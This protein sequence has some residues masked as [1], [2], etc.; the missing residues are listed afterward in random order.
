M[1]PRLELVIWAKKDTSE[2]VMLPMMNN[3]G[4]DVQLA[5]NKQ[6]GGSWLRVDRV[7]GNGEMIK[8]DDGMI[9][10]GF[11]SGIERYTTAIETLE[12]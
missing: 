4:K 5:L 7:S 6:F 10:Q 2:K 12:L 11:S 1:G 8:F 9:Y 3:R